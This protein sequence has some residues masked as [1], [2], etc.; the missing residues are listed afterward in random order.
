MARKSKPEMPE[1]GPENAQSP[2]AT[3]PPAPAPPQ[4]RTAFDIF[5]SDLPDEAFDEIFDQPREG[6]W[7]EADLE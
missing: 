6:G 5:G 3:P 7:R 4:A 1:G 2:R